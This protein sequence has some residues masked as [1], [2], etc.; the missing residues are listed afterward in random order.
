MDVSQRRA[1]GGSQFCRSLTPVPLDLGARRAEVKPQVVWLRD[2]CSRPCG[3]FFQGSLF[4]ESVIVCQG[5]G[6]GRNPVILYSSAACRGKARTVHEEVPPA[7]TGDACFWRP[8]P[9][10]WDG[11]QSRVHL[12]CRSFDPSTTTL[13]CKTGQPSNRLL[14]WQC[15]S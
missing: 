5:R 9:S 7:A 1:G 15:K 6:E 3:R 14:I 12:E 4:L 8:D 13:G 10:R 2:C 11:R